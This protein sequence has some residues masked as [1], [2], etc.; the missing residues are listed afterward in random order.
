MTEAYFVGPPSAHCLFTIATLRPVQLKTKTAHAQAISNEAH[1]SFITYR[2]SAMELNGRMSQ[3]FRSQTT[4][5]NTNNR[6]KQQQQNDSD[7]FM[8]L[9]RYLTYSNRDAG[10][11][12][13]AHERDQLTL[14][15]ARWGDR[16]LYHRHWRTFQPRRPPKA[17]SPANPKG[18]RMV[19]R[20]FDEH[21]ARD[22]G[23]SDGR[24]SRRCMR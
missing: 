3:Q 2:A 10:E 9:V 16:R 15:I 23:A 21:D 1:Y 12:P 19:R 24:C 14:M 17:K 22:S 5:N 13:S 20:A 6:G 18:T 7:A 8:R 11:D 4:F